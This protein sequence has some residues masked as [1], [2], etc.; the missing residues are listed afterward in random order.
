M[1]D[2]IREN[3]VWGQGSGVTVI[4]WA[5]HPQRGLHEWTQVH[6]HESRALRTRPPLQHEKLRESRGQCQWKVQ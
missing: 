2:S 1:L 5:A 3:A 6:G 4:A